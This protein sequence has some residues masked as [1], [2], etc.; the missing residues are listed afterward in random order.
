M[1]Y[2]PGSKVMLRGK[3]YIVLEPYYPNGYGKTNIAAYSIYPPGK[4]R[5]YGYHCWVYEKD[6]DQ[7]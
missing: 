2:K 1:K 5:S 3:R 6:L 7:K 4:R